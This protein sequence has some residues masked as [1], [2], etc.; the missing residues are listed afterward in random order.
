MFN[1]DSSL[2]I[3][4]LIF[5]EWANMYS[6]YVMTKVFFLKHIR[7]FAMIKLYGTF[8]P[9]STTTYIHARALTDYMTVEFLKFTE[10]NPALN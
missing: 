8:P 9:P 10:V 2:R 6:L 7:L 5:S 4:I 1:N 3:V